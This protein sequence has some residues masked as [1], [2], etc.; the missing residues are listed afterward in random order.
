MLAALIF[1]V[2]CLLLL[3]GM[4]VGFAML[5]SGALG[6]HLFG[7]IGLVWTFLKTTPLSTVS[8]FELLTVPM[9]ILMA[10][11]LVISRVADEM[12]DSVRAWLGRTHGG[13]AVATAVTGALFGAISG[14]STASA[15]TLSS[16]SLPAMLRHHYDRKLASGVVAISGTLAMLIPP[17]IALV[18]YAV[19]ADQS[20]AKML[21]AGVIPGLLVTLTIILTIYA[22]LWFHPDAAPRAESSSWAEKLSSLRNCGNF[23]LLFALVTG[24]IYLGVATPTE[25][26]A[27][28]AA[29]AAWLA[30]RRGLLNARSFLEAA[31]VTA[32][33]T[34]M[35]YMIII[36]AHVFGYF[37]TLTRVTQNLIDWVG[38]V[39][40]P[41]YLILIAVVVLYLILGCFMDQLAILILTVPIILPLMVSLGYDPIWLGVIIVLL[42]EVGM[43]TP[44]VG[45]NVFV[46]SRCTGMPVSEVF[47]GIWPHV[48][49]HIVLVA[50]L[51]AFPQII[52]WLPST[53]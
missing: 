8:S 5:V 14:S 46:V 41:V 17:S 25:A 6:L 38:A 51:I 43:V 13:L 30:W 42:A 32:R 26:S 10:Q 11:F 34:A 16:T 50:F 36:G 48:F 49:A 9:F 21:L 47:A 28:G 53:M 24:V 23:I 18:V 33:T 4:P 12:F 3:V 44:P 45:M 2:L 20:V 52:L 39:A 7:G 22:I 29:G 1:L 27:L 19:L 15:A 40:P 31:R 35:I 37:L